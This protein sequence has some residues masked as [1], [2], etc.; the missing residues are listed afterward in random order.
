MLKRLFNKWLERHAPYDSEPE[1]SMREIEVLNHSRGREYTT[2]LIE[3]MAMNSP[4]GT[5]RVGTH[6]VV[7]RGALG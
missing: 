1:I 5:V 4:T 3:S 7:R 2:R 6:V